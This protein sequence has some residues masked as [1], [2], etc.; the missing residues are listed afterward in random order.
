MKNI[1][2]RLYDL[3]IKLISVKTIPAV[4]FSIGYLN[5]NTFE[6]MCACLI[7]WALVIGIRYA[8]KVQG[9]VKGK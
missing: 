5:N 7:A 9:L 8:E 2:K 1:G 4:I 6:N 3:I